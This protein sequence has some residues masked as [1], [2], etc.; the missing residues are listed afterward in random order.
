MFAF[1]SFAFFNVAICATPGDEAVFHVVFDNVIV[2]QLP[3]SKA[4]CE[5][6][7]SHS[8]GDDNRGERKSLG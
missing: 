4:N 2:G 8:E 6:E 3:T 1:G 7:H 5:Q